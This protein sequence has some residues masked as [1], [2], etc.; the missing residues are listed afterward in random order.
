MVVR[1]TGAIPTSG[2]RK[3]NAMI[4]ENDVRNC[5]T[6]VERIPRLAGMGLRTSSSASEL[7]N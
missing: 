7:N 3:A 2:S 1:L 5:S 6:T 4:D